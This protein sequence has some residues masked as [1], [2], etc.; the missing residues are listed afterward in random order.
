[1]LSIQSVR[2]F[3]WQG[4]AP[5]NNKLL[6]DLRQDK[7]CQSFCSSLKTFET[8]NTPPAYT[9]LQPYNIK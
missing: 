1:M 9:K 6:F 3:N 4:A 2:V 7:W 5:L 8:F